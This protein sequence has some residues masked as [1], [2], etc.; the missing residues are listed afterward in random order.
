MEKKDPNT[1]EVAR[2]SRRSNNDKSK[3]ELFRVSLL[4]GYQFDTG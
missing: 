4:L 2:T 1:D 3:R